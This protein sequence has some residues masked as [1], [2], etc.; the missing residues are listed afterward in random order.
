M[1]VSR[2]PV[3]STRCTRCRRPG[4][5][6]SLDASQSAGLTARALGAILRAMMRRVLASVLLL[7]TLGASTEA[8]CRDRSGS[9][10]TDVVASQTANDDGSAAAGDACCA[11]LCA[12]QVGQQLGTATARVAAGPLAASPSFGAPT[13]CDARGTDAPLVRPPL[14]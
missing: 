5:V 9:G 11:C 4:R 7:A 13:P 1:R 2:A 6:V 12:C 3:N 10:A 14:A 8:F